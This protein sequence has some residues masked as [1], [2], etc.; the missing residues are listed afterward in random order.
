MMDYEVFKN[1]VTVRIKEFLPPIYSDFDV[2]VHEAM[3]VNGLREA[4]T[5]SFEAKECCI[6]GPN[7]YL[8]EMY[9]KFSECGDIEE[10][11]SDAAEMIIEFTAMQRFDKGEALDLKQY[12]DNI[13]HMLI[14][15]EQNREML[16]NVPHKE[17]LD[18]SVIYRIAVPDAD[19]RGY[20]TALITNDLLE[21]LDLTADELDRLAIINS[22]REL[23]TQLLKISDEMVMMTTEAKMFGAI[24]L[25][26]L[27]ELKALSEAMD[28]NLYI[29]PSSVHDLMII[30]DKGTFSEK[31]LFD[32]LKTGNDQ[33]NDIAENLSYNIYY[34]DRERNALEIRYCNS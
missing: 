34:Y 23:K 7:I 2:T 15:T 17:F 29:L 33:C 21:E 27:D 16:E 10:V 4:M 1:V 22:S 32:M 11:L 5:V 31:N 18:L 24:N 26:R 12:A 9:E 6:F 25:M 28:A 30:K 3:K 8:D 14:N 20:A 13:V 19:G